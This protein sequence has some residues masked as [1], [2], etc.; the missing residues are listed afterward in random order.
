MDV[1]N[2][3]RRG[4]ILQKEK[5]RRNSLSLCHYRSEPGYITIDHKNP[6]LL[7]TKKQAASTLTGNSMTL[8]PY[9]PLFME[10]KEISLG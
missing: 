6:A 7:A 1:S 3:I 2:V 10:E 9:K 5:D 4:P 8:V